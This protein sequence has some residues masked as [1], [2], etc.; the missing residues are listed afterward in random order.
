M[1]Y[2]KPFLL[3]LSASLA[4]IAPAPAAAPANPVLSVEGRVM[5][6]NGKPFLPIISWAQCAVDVEQNLAVGVNLFMQTHCGDFDAVGR[7]IGDREA[8]VIAPY[9]VYRGQNATPQTN[10]MVGYHQYDEPDMHGIRPE[11]LPDV[12]PSST[13]T[14]PVFM[15]L[16][17]KFAA[18]QTRDMPLSAYPEYAKKANV[19]GFDVYPLVQF[20]Y[21]SGTV[22]IEDAYNY[23]RELTQLF[24]GPTYQWIELT[25]MEGYCGNDPLTAAQVRAEIWMSFAG[26]ATALAYFTHNWRE[27]Q[28]YNFEI[29]PEILAEMGRSSR[30]AKELQS[31]LL[32]ALV[33]WK[34]V[35]SWPSSPVKVGARTLNGKTWI[36]AVNA[37]T[38]QTVKASFGVKG[39][40]EG[41][42]S[43]WKTD[44]KVTVKRDSITDSFAPGAVHFYQLDTKPVVKTVQAAPSPAAIKAAEKK[45]STTCAAAKAGSKKANAR[46]L[47]DACSDAKRK[48]A[49]LR[50]A[51][52]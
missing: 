36:I 8:Y 41:T 38:T 48:L 24:A 21:A 40:G 11:Q 34:Q 50:A 46:K 45:V 37:N 19:L 16:T 18:E 10:K 28:G 9:W 47:A 43:V 7:A 39:V 6:I 42:A 25:K 22:T 17:S 14:R 44:R 49:S 13:T 30:E 33:P 52:R 26:G 5:K 32:A 27:G 2:L 51:A 15:T 3:V 35:M 20:C 23:Q 31:V 1:R 29:K 4:L 12:E